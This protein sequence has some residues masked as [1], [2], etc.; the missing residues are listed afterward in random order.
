MPWIRYTGPVD[1][2]DVPLLQI[3]GARRLEPVEVSDDA[4]VALAGH[5][6]WEPC[7]APAAESLEG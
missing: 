1:R 7:D 2:V 6:E 3:G 4:A 5:P